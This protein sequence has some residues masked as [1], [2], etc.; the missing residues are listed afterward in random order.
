V[1]IHRRVS[2]APS[3]YGSRIA[4]S[5]NRDPFIEECDARYSYRVLQLTKLPWT[6]PT[7]IG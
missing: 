1:N 3:P 7:S 5:G 2:E 6:T 4:A